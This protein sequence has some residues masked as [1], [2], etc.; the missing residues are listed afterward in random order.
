MLDKEITKLEIK[1]AENPDANS[2][3]QYVSTKKEL[4]K[5]NDHLTRGIMIRA[6]PNLSNKM[7][8]TLNYF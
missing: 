1:Q 5:I 8:L 6:K 3:Q 4:E 2:L 7:K